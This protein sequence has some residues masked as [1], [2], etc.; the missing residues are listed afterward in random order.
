MCLLEAR[1]HPVD[2]ERVC[3]GRSPNLS[4]VEIGRTCLRQDYGELMPQK[5]FA[6]C[7]RCQLSFN[8]AHSKWCDCVQRTRS[9]VCPSC[10]RCS[11]D[12]PV[13][14]KQHHG[15]STLRPQLSDEPSL[16]AEDRGG[17]TK[18][19]FPR[20]ARVLVVDDDV[21]VQLL[22]REGLSMEFEVTTAKD[23]LEGLARALDTLPHVVVTDALMPTLDGRE[24]CRTL[25]SHP[26]TAGTRVV[27]M[28]SLYRSARHEREAIR[29][30]GADVFLRKPFTISALSDVIR[31]LLPANLR[32]AA[33]HCQQTGSRQKV[34]A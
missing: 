5:L 4:V 23:G 27:I 19:S 8:T 31:S 10:G 18:A 28:T 25:K 12:A 9:L 30:F 17:P 6:V 22:A 20:R 14:W 29:D 3:Q 13:E 33:E 1:V 26:K 21:F 24:L 15:S 11:C 32:V 16:D 2:R 7:F 34:P